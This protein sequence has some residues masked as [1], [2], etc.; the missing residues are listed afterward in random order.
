MTSQNK[1]KAS[2]HSA[3][4][5]TRCCARPSKIVF[6]V[7]VRAGVDFHSTLCTKNHFCFLILTRSYQDNLQTAKISSSQSLF[8]N[9]GP[10]IG[11][12]AFVFQVGENS[13]LTMWLQERH[14]KL[15]FQLKV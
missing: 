2:T 8:P 4:D 7:Q 13:L 11:I 3:D 6:S 15:P 12:L 5:Y 10:T 1:S 9:V 14:L